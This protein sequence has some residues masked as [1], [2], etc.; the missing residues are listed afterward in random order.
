MSFFSIFDSFNEKMP[1]SCNLAQNSKSVTSLM[2]DRLG[3]ASLS[4]VY[5]PTVLLIIDV[6][7]DVSAMQT[8]LL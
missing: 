7:G 6:S 2:E 5:S 8:A 4:L 3:S 1:I